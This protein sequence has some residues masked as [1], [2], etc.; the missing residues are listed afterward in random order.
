MDSQILDEENKLKLREMFIEYDQKMALEWK[1]I[2]RGSNENFDCHIWNERCTEKQNLIVIIHSEHG[3]IFG[4]YTERGWKKP[5]TM[6]YQLSYQQD[7]NA[8]LYLL[9]SE[10]NKNKK[11][12]IFKIKEEDIGFAIVSECN[13]MSCFGFNGYDM[14]ISNQCNKNQISW[15]GWRNNKCSYKTPPDNYLNHGIQNF[16]VIDIEV[17]AN[18]K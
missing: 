5:T 17:F 6:S 15:I 8:F 18:C 9:Q 12:E 2:Y 10:C 14:A 13:H 1:L 3:N 16:K 4:G 7:D 11:P